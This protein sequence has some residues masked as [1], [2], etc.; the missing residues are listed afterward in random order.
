MLPVLMLS[1]GLVVPAGVVVPA[2]SASAQ[3]SAHVHVVKNGE[4]LWRISDR[5]GVKLAALLKENKLTDN[6]VIIPGQK[7]RIPVVSQGTKSA[8][9][10]KPLPR[11]FPASLKTKDSLALIPHFERAAKESGIPVDLLMALALTESS[12][13][14][15]V[16][17]RDGAIGL[18]QLLPATVDWVGPS[19]LRSRKLDPYKPADNLRMTAAY[20]KW[21]LGQFKGDTIKALA[22]YY[23]G[24][25]TV[26]KKG[27]TTSGARYAR[28]VLANRSLFA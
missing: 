24:A 12:W 20:V 6:S 27:P 16:V 3:A 2:R 9:L 13:R 4:T 5:Y 1:I 28:T 14:T 17:S 15:K 22:A 26:Q 10:T 25:G 19:L 11:R 8:A 18:G 7:L 23:E 21:L